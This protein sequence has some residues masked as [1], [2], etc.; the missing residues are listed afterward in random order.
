MDA[1]SVSDVV[2]PRSLCRFTSSVDTSL[3]V[4]EENVRKKLPV[5]SSAHWL[6]TAHGAKLGYLINRILNE[7]NKTSE[8]WYTFFATSTLEAMYA[9]IRLCRQAAKEKGRSS[10]RKVLIYDR[11]LQYL[12][13]FDPLGK[14]PEQALCPQVY[15]AATEAKFMEL[16]SLHREHW[17]CTILITYPEQ[18]IST[19]T[20]QA[21][22]ATSRSV[23]AWNVVCNSEKKLSDATAFDVPGGTHIVIFGENLTNNEVPFG[24]FALVP[25]AYAV[26]GSRRQLTSYTSTFAGNATAL[27]A[28]LRALSSSKAYVNDIDRQLFTQIDDSF[29]ERIACF[30]KHV[31]PAKADLFVAERKDLNIVRAEGISLF[32]ANGREILD[33]AT[34]GCSLRGHNPSDIIANVLHQ[35]DSEVDY[36]SLVEGKLRRLSRFHHVLPAVSGAGAVDN[37]IIMALLAKPAKKKIISF[38]GNFSGKTLVSV[39]FSKSAPL[40][41]DFDLPAYEPYYDDVIYIDPFSDDAEERFFQIASA[42]D[43]ALVWFELVQGYM[44]KRLPLNLLKAVERHKDQCG[45][46]IGVDEVL[47]GMWKNARTVLYHQENLS[48]VDIV[49]MSKATSDLIFPVSWALVT[50]QVFRAASETAQSTVDLLRSFHRTNLGGMIALNALEAGA[51]FFERND[52]QDSLSNFHKEIERLVASSSLFT[53][54]TAE[55]SF[56]RFNV[57][58]DWFPYDED[59]IERTLVEGAISTLILNST[60]VMLTNLRMF[61]PS[62]H[63]AEVQSRIVQRLR[64]GIAKI[65]PTAV[66]TFMLCLNYQT[67]EALGMSKGI[68][69]ILLEATAAA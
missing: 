51:E 10:P 36:F 13:F 64:T 26:W 57:N 68:K 35:Y 34:L 8:T 37:A 16:L 23:D 20:R 15:F 6:G 40:L 22:E 31:H 69:Q 17:A 30:A 38:T 7:A 50:D 63:S 54:I 33:T 14:G 67:L 39:N 5:M 52:L 61:L 9:V 3:G 47:T 66:Y 43:I 48:K 59:S 32:L 55:G 65:T 19:D 29:D 41:A 44:L 2:G 60:G 45:Y 28:A 49:S 4:V 46:L 42:G 24:A 21:L 25:S 58:K 11:E 53:D 12:P 56:I 62:I 1:I 27:S 18:H